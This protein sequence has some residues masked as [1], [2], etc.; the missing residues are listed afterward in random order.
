MILVTNG[1]SFTAG[2]T[3]TDDEKSFDQ[4][5]Y[6]NI[7]AKELNCDFVNLAKASG[8]NDR[9]LRTTMDYLLQNKNKDLFVFLSLT[10]FDRFELTWFNEDDI[11]WIKNKPDHLTNI[12][13]YN[14]LFILAARNKFNKRINNRYPNNPLQNIQNYLNIYYEN[15]HDYIFQVN[16]QLKQFLLLESF[17]KLHNIKYGFSWA[18]SADAS[19]Y[20]IFKEFDIN[21][22]FEPNSCMVENLK[23]K[24]F[25][26]DK[27]GHFYPEAYENYGK[28]IANW[29]KNK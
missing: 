8:S 28:Q 1:D 16:R 18:I 22:W 5:A 21:N 11:N 3:L 17:F 9:I 7:T 25:K 10:T 2:Y 6:G 23:N 19:N 4:Y 29:I 13:Y 26:E 27:T 20:E 15:S 14:D 24:N 12:D